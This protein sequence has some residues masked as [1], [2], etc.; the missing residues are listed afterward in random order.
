MT[1]R[2]YLFTADQY[3]KIFAQSR[4]ATVIYSSEEMHIGFINNAMLNLWNKQDDIIGHALLAVAP[5][6]EPFIPILKEV[7]ISGEPYIAKDT[8]ANIDING[9]LI[10]RYFDF[11]YRPVL[12]DTGKT[13]AIINT[14][15]D[16]TDRMR[17]WEL[18]QEKEI[19]EQRLNEDLSAI[20]EA[21]ETMIEEMRSTNEELAE[22]QSK[23]RLSNDR[24]IES[25][26]RIRSIFEQ[27]PVGIGIFSGPE[28]TIEMANKSI[29]SIWGRREEDVVGKPH[30]IARPELKGQPVYQ[31]L[32]D[33]FNTGITRTNNEFRVMLYDQGQL[34]EAYVNS[35]YQPI[36][37][38]SGEVNGVMV[39]LDEIT[40]KIR[41]QHEVM[42][43]QDM[44]NLAIEA[45]ELGTFYYDPVTNLFSGNNLL[46]SWFG[47]QP[48]EKINLKLAIDVI[49]ETDRQ[50]VV[51]AIGTAL[52]YSSGSNYDI[53]Y[54]IV[55]PKTKISR[56]VRAKGKATFDQEQQP[57]SLNG[58]LQ[59]ITEGKQDEQRKND[60][61]GMVSHELKT[62]L[63]SLKGYIQLLQGKMV[64]DSFAA[65]ALDKAG[66]QVNKMT[67][68]INGFLNLSSLE[69]GKIQL[70]IQ[71][72]DIEELIAEVT[73]ELRITTSSHPIIFEQKAP[74]FINGDRNKIGQVVNNLLTNAL[75][76][77]AIGQQIE[78]SS[79]LM[80]DTIV[81][82]IKDNGIG[83]K[84]DDKERLFERYYRVDNS[85]MPNISG[86]GIGLYLSAEIIHRH[87]GKIWAESSYGHGST[88][89]FSLPV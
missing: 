16:V 7:W 43:A 84:P 72:F 48:D 74:V 39:I 25:E 31:W 51:S 33:V 64:Q 9:N 42:R 47:L 54:T 49:A 87:N 6:F 86:F 82:S 56:I 40:D 85:A 68:M 53:V 35:I 29:L 45:G 17:A 88:F 27:A 28:H 24:L 13:Y 46:K 58:T 26:D 80:K 14:A 23:L 5:E 34:R 2:N 73:S 4:E 81:I 71:S 57:V 70:A 89:Y 32:D 37:N 83:I 12:D 55:N 60:F 22:T 30:H 66:N 8:P 18:V 10:Q 3:L 59:D 67:T 15:I 61:I 21:Q 78:L 41:T 65:L 20:N 76:Y 63:T 1:D 77:S 69:A 75:K 44:L 11:E 19:Y 50:R 38:A 62:P 79:A 52:T 36:R